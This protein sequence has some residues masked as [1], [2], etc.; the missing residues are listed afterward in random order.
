MWRPRPRPL[1]EEES[2]MRKFARLDALDA[3]PRRRSKAPL[4]LLFILFAI[5]APPTFEVV[6][7]N[8]ARLGLFGMTTPVDT[9]ILDV[10]NAQ[11]HARDSELRDWITPLLVNRRWNPRLVIPIAFLWTALAAWL[12]RKGHA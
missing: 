4:V 3:P 2:A 11:W 6:K 12:L 9:P 5:A 1:E 8:L 7:L 10:L